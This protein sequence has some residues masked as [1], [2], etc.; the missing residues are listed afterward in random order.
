MK[1][2]KT[3]ALC[4]LFLLTAALSDC[5]ED[6]ESTPTDPFGDLVLNANL[7]V[8]DNV[9]EVSASVINGGDRWHAKY[10][11]DLDSRSNNGYNLGSVQFDYGPYCESQSSGRTVTCLVQVEAESG[12]VKQAQRTGKVCS[13]G[14]SETDAPSFSLLF[15]GSGG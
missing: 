8:D 5:W 6:G 10:S 2:T 1:M 14:S 13:D 4:L 7:S 12:Q 11:C 15:G 9:V 3:A